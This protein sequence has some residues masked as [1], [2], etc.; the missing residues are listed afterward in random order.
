MGIARDLMDWKAHCGW[1]NSLPGILYYVNEERG[2]SSSLCSPL[3]FSEATPSLLWW[4]RPSTVHQLHQNKHFFSSV[5]FGRVFHQRQT[6]KPPGHCLISKD[7]QTVCKHGKRCH[8]PQGHRSLPMK[9]SVRI[10]LCTYRNGW[11]FKKQLYNKKET[12]TLSCWGWGG[13]GLLAMADG[14]GT[15]TL[16]DMQATSCNIRCSQPKRHGPISS[17]KTLCVS[18]SLLLVNLQTQKTQ[19]RFH[20]IHAVVTTVHL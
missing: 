14:D 6:I 5:A 17:Q 2:L 20:L 3:C 11:L 19:L 4:T 15:V 16:E 10:A 12:L 18:K 9:I 13:L 1:H 7:K 8:S